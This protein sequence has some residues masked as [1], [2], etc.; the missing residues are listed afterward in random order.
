VSSHTDRVWDLVAAAGTTGLT[1]SYDELGEVLGL[2]PTTVKRIVRRLE[3]DGDIEVFHNPGRGSLLR[4]PG[5]T[6]QGDQTGHGHPTPLRGVWGGVT[7]PDQT[8]HNRQVTPPARPT[9]TEKSTPPTPRRPDPDC[10]RCEGSGW[11]YVDRDATTV[12]ACDC[13]GPE[14]RAHHRRRQAELD[15]TWGNRRADDGKVAGPDY[16]AVQREYA[17]RL[18]NGEKIDHEDA[19]ILNLIRDDPELDLSIEHHP[20]STI[21]NP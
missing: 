3:D 17:R 6:D 16:T 1:A 2:S 19:Q 8:G 20:T 7:R 12:V 13:R 21:W 18:L 14:T 15:A 4:I 9:R 10:P 11:N 5:G